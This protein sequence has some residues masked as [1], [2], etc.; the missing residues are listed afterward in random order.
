VAFG[1]GNW[2]TLQ[3]AEELLSLPN[4]DTVRGK[5]DRALL[6][7]LIGAGLRRAETAMLTF[8]HIQQ[9]VSAA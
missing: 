5:R 1:S 4:H 3:Q 8:E 9:R 2:L 6:S 7:V